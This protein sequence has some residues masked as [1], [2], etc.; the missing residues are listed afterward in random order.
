MEQFFWK[1]TNKNMKTKTE[2]LLETSLAY[3]SNTL[4]VTEGGECVYLGKNGTRCAFSRCCKNDEKTNSILA[5]V[6][7]WTAGKVLEKFG[8][9]VLEEE[10]RGH[11]P[12]FWRNVQF[13]H[14]CLINWDENGISAEGKKC[15]EELLYVYRDREVQNPA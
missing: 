12:E 15:L 14:D 10:Y 13:F 8:E 9:E 11:S 5:G 3:N 7:R 4:S 1:S 6:Q 2:I